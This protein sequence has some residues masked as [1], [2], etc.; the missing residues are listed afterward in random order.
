MNNID[1][2]NKNEFNKCAENLSNW[3][4]LI[5]KDLEDNKPIE[6]LD[7]SNLKQALNWFDIIIGFAKIC[8]DCKGET[9]FKGINGELDTMCEKCNGRGVITIG[10]DGFY[11]DECSLCSKP[12]LNGEVHKECSDRETYLANKE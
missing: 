9:G 2:Y 7:I 1:L 10:T 4:D 6:P 8:P 12:S 5:L 11:K 3:A